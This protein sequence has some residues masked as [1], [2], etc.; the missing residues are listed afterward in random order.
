MC[1][2]SLVKSSCAQRCDCSMQALSTEDESNTFR[3][4]SSSGSKCTIVGKTAVSACNSEARKYEVPCACSQCARP[5]AV[6]ISTRAAGRA[7][8]SKQRKRS[9]LC[10][11][12]KMA[13]LVV[14]VSFPASQKPQVCRV[15]L[16]SMLA[17][18]LGTEASPTDGRLGQAIR[19]EICNS[20]KSTLT[21]RKNP[22][23]SA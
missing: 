15:P 2:C 23:P 18:R 16:L 7:I 20:P 5:P 13:H 10:I 21:Q 8:P 14:L 3:P 1:R 17:P 12:M 9:R 22:T 19:V 6:Q 11:R 4:M